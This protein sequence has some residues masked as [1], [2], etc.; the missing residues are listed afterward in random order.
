MHNV[1]L[2]FYMRT[3]PKIGILFDNIEEKGITKQRKIEA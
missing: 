3:S 1:L 2:R